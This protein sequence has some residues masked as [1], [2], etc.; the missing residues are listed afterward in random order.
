MVNVEH[1]KHDRK[2]PT[3]KTMNIDAVPI[4]DKDD[5]GISHT[6]HTPQS[7]LPMNDR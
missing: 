1:R 5:V 4:A 3:R 2:T 7:A 6:N